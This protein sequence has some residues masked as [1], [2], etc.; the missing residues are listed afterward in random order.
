MPKY[1]HI[2]TG[3]VRVAKSWPGHGWLI[4]KD[5]VATVVSATPAPAA[6]AIAKGKGKRARKRAA[7]APVELEP[8]PVTEPVEPTDP[9]YD[10][11]PVG[12]PESDE[13]ADEETAS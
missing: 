2:Q 1:R 4:V 6:I 9:V 3:A 5:E 7:A 11:Q 13:T 10:D 12:E 8:T